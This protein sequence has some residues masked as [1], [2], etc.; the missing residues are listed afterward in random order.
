MRPSFVKKETAHLYVEGSPET[1]AGFIIT[2]DACVRN[3]FTC[4]SLGKALRC[5]MYNPASGIETRK[6]TQHDGTVGN[7]VVMDRRGN[8]SNI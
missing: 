7:L 1:L 2:L 4:C 3:L 5:A 6:G 8:I